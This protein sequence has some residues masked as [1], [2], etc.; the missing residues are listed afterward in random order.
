VNPNHASNEPSDD[1]EDAAEESCCSAWG[2]AAAEANC[3]VVADA[4]VCAA[5][6][7]G[8]PAAFVTT[9]AWSVSPSILVVCGGGMNGVI[10]VASDDALAYPYMAAASWAHISPYC[11]SVAAI[12]GLFWPKKF[13]AINA[14]SWA[15]LAAIT[16][17][18]TVAANAVS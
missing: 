11:A 12:A 17:G 1:V 5:V 6:P 7:A 10:V 14:A 4:V 18:G 15:R 8:V 9:A 13:V 3:G 2:T 16:G